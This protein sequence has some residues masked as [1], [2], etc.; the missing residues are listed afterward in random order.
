MVFS[1]NCLHNSNYRVNWRYV[2]PL[3]GLCAQFKNFAALWSGLLNLV[4][5]F[6]SKIH[7]ID[8]LLFLFLFLLGT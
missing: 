6:H 8:M 2:P 3:N 7:T 4:V 1:E 5:V